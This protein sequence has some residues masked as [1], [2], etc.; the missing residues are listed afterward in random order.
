VE[1]LGLVFSGADV[2][3]ERGLA[4]R[5]RVRQGTQAGEVQPGEG[6]DH[7]VL[8]LS[9]VLLALHLFAVVPEN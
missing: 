8:N 3:G 5:G 2:Q 4:E 7:E 9:G 6:H 1:P